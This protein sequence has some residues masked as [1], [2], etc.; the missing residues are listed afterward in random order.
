[1]AHP[2]V[3]ALVCFFAAL[4]VLLALASL[5]V[6][7]R[8]FYR[9]GVIA[10]NNPP[11]QPSP[12]VNADPDLTTPRLSWFRRRIIEYSP[13]GSSGSDISLLE[14]TPAGAASSS[15]AAAN[16]P[17]GYQTSAAMVFPAV[18][19]QPAQPAQA[20]RDDTPLPTYEHA[21]RQS[22]NG[23]RDAVDMVWE[24][25]D[26]GNGVPSGQGTRRQR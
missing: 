15:S 13:R 12:D 23:P 17:Q 6:L 21:R 7:C 24:E 1:M 10:G 14:L 19:S 4:V 20:T 22:V 26:L 25:I 18:S 8:F 11:Q 9:T 16:R 2:A 5:G 3:I